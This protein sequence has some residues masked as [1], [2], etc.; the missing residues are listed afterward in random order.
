[1]DKWNSNTIETMEGQN[2]PAI[3]VNLF[4]LESAADC[5]A[6]ANHDCSFNISYRFA[7]DVIL[8]TALQLAFEDMPVARIT[9]AAGTLMGFQQRL[10]T[11]R[12]CLTL[13][14]L[15]EQNPR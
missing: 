3:R 15:A 14:G 4:D 6:S 13:L 5:M 11:T 1:M 10:S 12:G 7:H 8:R 2:P 9:F